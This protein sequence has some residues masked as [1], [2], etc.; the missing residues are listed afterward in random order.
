MMNLEENMKVAS[1]VDTKKVSVHQAEVPEIADDEV[2]IQVAYAGICGSDIHLF[3]GS[4]AFRKPPA[5]LGHEMSGKIVKIG[6]QVVKFA[7]GDHV[8]VEPHVGC[9]QCQFCKEDLVNIC[10]NKKVPG[11]PEW[12]GTFAQYFNAP[13]SILYKLADKVSFE[14]G[15]LVEPLAVAIH[16]MNRITNQDKGVIAILGAGTIGLLIQ[17]VAR[18]WGYEKV[19]TTDPAPFNRQLSIQFGAIASLDPLTEDVTAYINNLTEHKGVDV[20]M[21]SAG[22]DNILDQAC[23]LTK[24]RGEIGI[25]SMITKKI[26][27]YSYAPVFKE[28]TIFG[29]MTYET[30]DFV[31]ATDMINKGLDLSALVTH[32]FDLDETEK[33]LHV[34]NDKKENVG[35]ILIKIDE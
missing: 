5:I 16:A 30:K 21:I 34:L 12:V 20:T 22:S 29:C 14:M 6:R 19:I 26:P 33:G 2:L 8:T 18:E 27:F 17:V 1:V 15:V 25:V 9:G 31:Q 11:T 32:T 7:V 28:Q 23:E 4:H 3:I 10:T 13:E 35:K 24:K